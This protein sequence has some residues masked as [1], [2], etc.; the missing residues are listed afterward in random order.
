MD[1]ADAKEKVACAIAGLTSWRNEEN[2]VVLCRAGQPQR[3]SG[4]A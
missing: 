2:R 4:S 1:V 3:Q